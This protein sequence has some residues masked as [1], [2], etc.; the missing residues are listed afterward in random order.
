[1]CRSTSS[2]GL[3]YGRCDTINS[4]TF[5]VT[6]ERVSNCSLLALLQL[7]SRP[8][9]TSNIEQDGSPP[10]RC[11]LLIVL[12]H[13]FCHGRG[14]GFE[15][16]RPRHLDSVPYESR[17]RFFFFADGIKSITRTTAASSAT[18]VPQPAPNSTLY[19]NRPVSSAVPLVRFQS[20]EMVAPGRF[21]LPTSGLGNRCSIHLSY[22]ATLY[23]KTYNSIIFTVYSLSTVCFAK[24]RGQL[25]RCI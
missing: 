9:T 18:A 6:P 7:I 2:D 13:L 3:A 12:I 17:W 4:A 24:R 20:D 11:K 25:L 21:E 19:R 1:M 15:S 10:D 5:G 22:G 8:P 16:R 23:S 14:R